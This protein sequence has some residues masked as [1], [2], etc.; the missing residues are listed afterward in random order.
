MARA[1]IRYCFNVDDGKAIR[2]EIRKRLSTNFVNHGTASWECRP[3]V[4]AGDAISDIRWA[5]EFVQEQ[6]GDRPDALD[7][8]WVYIDDPSSNPI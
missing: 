4:S 6:I 1:I 2:T 7:H 5:L 3:D 8:I